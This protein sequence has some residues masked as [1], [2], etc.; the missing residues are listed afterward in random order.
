MG[1]ASRAVEEVAGHADVREGDAVADEEGALCGGAGGARRRRRRVS[2]GWRGRRARGGACACV[3]RCVEEEDWPPRRGRAGGATAR[4][5]RGAKMGGEGG[6]RRTL[7]D[8][9]EGGEGPIEGLLGGILLLRSRT[10]PGTGDRSVSP[11]TRR[12]HAQVR[13]ARR[14]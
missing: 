11:L 2:A 8:L 6:R 12:R 10:R 9:V 14:G 3:G 7:E 4:C 5:G 13:E 1:G